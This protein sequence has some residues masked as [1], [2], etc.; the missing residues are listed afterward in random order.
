MFLNIKYLLL[1]DEISYSM[2]K[3]NT[4]KLLK[5]HRVKGNPEMLL[6]SGEF[7]LSL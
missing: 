3:A 1:Y 2:K 4:G 5:I 6:G 7:E